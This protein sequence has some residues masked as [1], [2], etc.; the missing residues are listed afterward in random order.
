MKR[1]KKRHKTKIDKEFVAD[2]AKKI[3]KEDFKRLNRKRN[4][5]KKILNL[6]VFA[7]QKGK[8]KLLLEILS[9]YRKGHYRK[10]PWR[11]VAAITF[12]LLYIINPLDMIPDV[13]PVVGYVDDISV[14][15]G[16]LKLINQ[17]IDDYLDWKAV[18]K[19]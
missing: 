5:L 14:F 10:L 11:S 2:E 16:L 4:R 1:M 15:I 3:N 13:L 9:Q 12:T 6:K 18:Q 19:L 8:L 17:D 7:K